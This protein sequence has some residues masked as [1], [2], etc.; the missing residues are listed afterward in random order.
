MF[1]GT[2]WPPTPVERGHLYGFAT[3]GAES[4]VPNIEALASTDTISGVPDYIHSTI[5]PQSAKTLILNPCSSSHISHYGPL[6][7]LILGL[8][9]PFSKGALNP[10]P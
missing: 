9:D 3:A 4:K 10:K 8:M 2:S 7:N 6:F 5:C 1:R